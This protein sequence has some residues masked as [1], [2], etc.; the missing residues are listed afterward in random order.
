MYTYRE[1]MTSFTLFALPIL[2]LNVEVPTT[3]GI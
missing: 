2:Y 3:V 1:T